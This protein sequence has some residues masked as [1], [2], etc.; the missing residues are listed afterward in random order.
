MP[1]EWLS[2]TSCRVQAAVEWTVSAR[3]VGWIC[4]FVSCLVC[5]LQCSVKKV[6]WD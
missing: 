6:C 1:P 2:L 3:T 4:F 5:S